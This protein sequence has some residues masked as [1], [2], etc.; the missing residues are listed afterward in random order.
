MKRK[1]KVRPVSVGREALVQSHKP[2][3]RKLP[4][5]QKKSDNLFT[6]GAVPADAEA[7][8]KA[9]EL[10]RLPISAFCLKAI[11]GYISY[12]KGAR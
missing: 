2:G 10:E 5:G 4:P 11:L 6:F 7:I 1:D 12:E 9:A 3:R 8:R